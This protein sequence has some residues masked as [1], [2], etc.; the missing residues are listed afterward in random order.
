MW[1]S[2]LEIW[3][4]DLILHLD[5]SFSPIKNCL[6]SKDN[7][8]S[9]WTG[10]NFFISFGIAS[11]ISLKRDLLKSVRILRGSKNLQRLENPNESFLAFIAGEDRNEF[12]IASNK[13]SDI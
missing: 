4:E 2:V 8:H 11:Q 10:W 7:I 1:I 5:Q 9:F 12:G 3:Q 6:K 13:Y